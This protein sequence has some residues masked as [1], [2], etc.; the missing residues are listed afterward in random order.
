MKETLTR[1]EWLGWLEHSLEE[2][3]PD[4]APVRLTEATRL[5][6]DLGLDSLG[7]EELFARLQSKL[8]GPVPLLQ[9]YNALEAAGG[10]VGTLLDLIESHGAG[11]AAV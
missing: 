8:P 11:D 7:F 4:L 10:R 6:E 2:I 9:W 1:A 5:G 3:Q